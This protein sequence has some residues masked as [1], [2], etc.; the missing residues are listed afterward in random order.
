MTMLSFGCQG[1]HSP[2]LFNIQGVSYSLA[3]VHLSVYH[4]KQ[5]MYAIYL[6]QNTLI[7]QGNTLG[8]TLTTF[9]TFPK[10]KV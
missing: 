5:L 8:C 7:I 1:L 9:D 6:Q 2:H 3:T 10:D 4:S